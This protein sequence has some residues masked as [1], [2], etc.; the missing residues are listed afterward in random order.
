MMAIQCSFKANFLYDLSTRLELSVEPTDRLEILSESYIIL[1]RSL[2][3]D[4][5]TYAALKA[6][7]KINREL[8]I[9]FGY[10]LALNKLKKLGFKCPFTF[11]NLDSLYILRAIVNYLSKEGEPVEI[12]QSISFAIDKLSLNYDLSFSKMKLESKIADLVV[13]KNEKTLKS[14]RRGTHILLALSVANILLVSFFLICYT[15]LF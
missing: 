13:V 12:P 1:A 6:L 3:P 9:S 15:H 8:G 5:K 4:S 10:F 2:F 11:Q 7:A 14:I